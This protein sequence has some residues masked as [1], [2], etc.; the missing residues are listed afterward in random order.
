[1]GTQGDNRQTEAARK[2]PAADQQQC[3]TFGQRQAG[4]SRPDRPD[5]QPNRIPDWQSNRRAS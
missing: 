5:Q 4:D 3:E 2:P 1:M